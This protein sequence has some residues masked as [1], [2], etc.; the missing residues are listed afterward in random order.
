MIKDYT[1]AEYKEKTDY[2]IAF[3]DGCNNG[4]SFPC[5]KNGNLLED[6][7]DAARQ[8]HKLCLQHPEKFK[9]FNTIVEYKYTVK[10]PAHGTCSCGETVYLY[11]QYYGACQCPNC[12]KWYNLFG[13]EL[14]PPEQWERDP[15]K[16][17]YYEEW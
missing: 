12:Y 10:E 9:R 6:V 11:D 7:P 16:V 8:N 3:D 2:E 13:Q 4:F 15:S 17:E 5:D 1:P 14:L